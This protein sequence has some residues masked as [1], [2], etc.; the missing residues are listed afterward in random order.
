MLIAVWFANLLLSF[1]LYLPNGR[2]VGSESIVPLVFELALLVF[3]LLLLLDDSEELVTLSLRLLGQHDLSFNELSTTSNVKIFSL[4]TGKFGLF[5]FFST[6]LALTFFK[7]TL[8]S[9]GV[10]LTLTVSRT[11][12][13]LSQPLNLKFFL[14]FDA[15][16]LTGFRLLLGNSFS[17]VTHNF[18]IL[19]PLLLKFI[20]LA[21]KS[22]FVGY[23][24]FLEHFSVSCLLNFLNGD[25]GS[26]LLLDSSNHLLLLTLELLAFFDAG[27]FT[28][29]D[30]L[31]DDSSASA[32]GLLS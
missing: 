1:F 21:I 29:L 26:F 17:I 18:Q 15:L 7:G 3:L 20:L 25:I 13:K 22:N 32:L 28:F 5:F 4:Y 23:L 2:R 10:D 16:L 12:L 8:S 31:Y 14:L 6:C 19:L 24:N 9:Q 27:S 11:L 30:L